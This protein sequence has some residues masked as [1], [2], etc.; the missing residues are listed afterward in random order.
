MP[1]SQELSAPL[2]QIPADIVTPADYQRIFKHFVRPDIFEYIEGGVADDLTLNSNRQAFDNIKLIPKVLANFKQASTQC[3]LVEQPLK[4]P[5]LLA[6]VAYQKLVHPQGELATIEAANAMNIGL[7]ASTLATTPL[8][9]MA[10]KLTTNKWFQLYFQD[11]KEN[12]LALVKRAEQAGYT[13]LIVTIDAPVNGLRNRAQRAGFS[14]P[15]NVH[16]VNLINNTVSEISVFCSED[17]TEKCTFVDLTQ[18]PMWGPDDASIYLYDD[19]H[20]N[21]AG[22]ELVGGQVWSTLESIGAYR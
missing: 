7:I 13:S 21:V 18:P 1:T 4:Y 12:T 2:S 20:V 3:T 11:N 15:E 22:A 5:F 8:E 17:P 16:A 6:P 14:M 9:D 19:K 10:D